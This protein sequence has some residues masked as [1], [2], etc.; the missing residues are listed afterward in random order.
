MRGDARSTLNLAAELAKRHDVE[1]IS[2]KRHRDKPFFPVSSKVTMR[3]LFDTRP[4]VRQRQL[5]PSGQ[6]RADVALWRML[7]ALRTDVLI[8]TRPGL[9]VHSARYAPRE[10]TRIARE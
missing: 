4:G 3:W 2:V 9:S 1:I 8:T 6:V 7:R 5:F 10:I